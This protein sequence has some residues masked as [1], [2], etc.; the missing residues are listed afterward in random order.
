MV[1]MFDSDDVLIRKVSNGYVVN[2]N[3]AL[4]EETICATLEEVVKIVEEKYSE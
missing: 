1:S 3:Y 2:P 4:G